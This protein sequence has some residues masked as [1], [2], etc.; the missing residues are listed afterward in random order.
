LAI[1]KLKI[2]LIHKNS[3]TIIESQDKQK[4]RALRIRTAPKQLWDGGGNKDSPRQSQLGPLLVMT[5]GEAS[6]ELLTATCWVARVL[7]VDLFHHSPS[8]EVPVP[9]SLCNSLRHTQ[10]IQIR[11]CQA[12]VLLQAKDEAAP[13]RLLQYG[14]L[15]Q[16]LV[17]TSPD[18]QALGRS[19]SATSRSIEFGSG[20]SMNRWTTPSPV[21]LQQPSAPWWVP[22]WILQQHTAYFASQSSGRSPDENEAVEIGKVG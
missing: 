2:P 20:W 16:W 6:S 10:K 9:N 8:A 3:S 19:A 1:R 17:K 11:R 4:A 14:S 12:S 5:H 13:E 18:Y 22:S 7:A 21:H 15:V